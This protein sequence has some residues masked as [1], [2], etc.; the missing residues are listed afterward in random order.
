MDGDYYIVVDDVQKDV[1]VCKYIFDEDHPQG[2][3]RKVFTRNY[4]NDSAFSFDDAK[5]F[6]D[7]LCDIFN[8]ESFEKE[9]VNFVKT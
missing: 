2:Y 6:C 8:S 7:S 9:S 3:E 4:G 5:G 1:H